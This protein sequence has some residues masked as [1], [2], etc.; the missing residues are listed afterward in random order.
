MKRPRIHCSV[1]VWLPS[2]ILSSGYQ[3][4]SPTT[5]IS[6]CLPNHHSRLP[7][8]F[9]GLPVDRPSALQPAIQQII[10]RAPVRARRCHWRRLPASNWCHLLHTERQEAR[11]GCTWP[12]GSKLLPCS[13]R[14]RPG[15]GARQFR[16]GRIRLHRSQRQEVGAC[17]GHWQPC[18]AA[19]LWL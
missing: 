5:P 17:T 7:Q 4:C 16:T 9:G 3:V 19:A 14:K 6:S 13:R 12:Q 10:I 18:S 11:R 1:L 2:L 8:I 15:H